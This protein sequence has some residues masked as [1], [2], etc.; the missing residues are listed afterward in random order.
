MAEK[1]KLADISE[2]DVEDLDHSKTYQD[3]H[4]HLSCLAV[5]VETPASQL[6]E[7]MRLAKV[8]FGGLNKAQE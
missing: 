1:S 8:G 2:A 5:G 7:I 4:Y 6:T 3:S